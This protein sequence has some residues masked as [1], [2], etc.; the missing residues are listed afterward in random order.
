MVL[1]DFKVKAVECLINNFNAENECNDCTINI[2]GVSLL[3]ISSVEI[4]EDFVV[5]Y[6]CINSYNYN[7][8]LVA[9]MSIDDINTMWY[10]DDCSNIVSLNNIEF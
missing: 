3:H 5:V 9:C 10:L 2:N 6:R 4:D 8:V 1:E 7:R